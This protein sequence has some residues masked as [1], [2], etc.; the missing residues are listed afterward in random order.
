MTAPLYGLRGPG[1]G[2]ADTD[3]LATVGR[4]VAQHGGAFLGLNPVHAGFWAASEGYS[5]YSPSHRRRLSAFHIPTTRE[6]GSATA[7][8]GLIDYPS[9]LA[10][11]RAALE[12]AY[13]AKKDSAEFDAYLKA[14]GAALIRFATHQALSDLHGAYWTDWPAALQSPDSPE[15]ARAAATLS[16]EIRFHAWLQFRAAQGLAQAQTAMTTAGAPIGL[17]LDLAVGTHPA[18]AETWEDHRSFAKGVSLGAP[19]DAFS[20]DGQRWGLAPFNPHALIATGFAPLAETLRSLFRHAGAVRIDHIL[21]FDRAFWV[22]DTHG[23]P[24]AYVRMPRDAMLAVLRLEAARVGGVVIGE[25]LG[26]VPRGLRGALDK[27]GILG[28]RVALFEQAGEPP[29]FRDPKHYP[30]AALASFSTHD[31]PTW[32]GWRA[33][34]DIALRRDLGHISGAAAEAHLARRSAEVTGFDEMTSRHRPKGTPSE[35]HAGVCHAMAASGAALVAVQAETA[36]EVT[37]QPN[38]PGTTDAYPNWQQPLPVAAKDWHE[39]M[40]LLEVAEIMQTHGRGSKT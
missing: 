9:A 34:H 20:S 26:N 40:R 17:Y 22:P 1:A 15:T 5:P 33:G 13:A 27:A 35:R 32:R 12:R 18:G 4:A 6:P 25:D 28:C 38:L 29:R 23:L 30:A 3:D 21:G 11:K 37:A 2:L 39:D 7:G 8:G 19:P 14:E 36:F 10:D 16:Q 24:G 31:L